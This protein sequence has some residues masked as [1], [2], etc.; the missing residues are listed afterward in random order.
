VSVARR[1]HEGVVD[2]YGTEKHEQRLT[3]DPFGDRRADSG[4]ARAGRCRQAPS[5]RSV[6]RRTDAAGDQQVRLRSRQSDELTATSIEDH[7]FEVLDA[8]KK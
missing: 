4:E 2:P 5:I 3:V 7:D 8:T 1:H 6:A